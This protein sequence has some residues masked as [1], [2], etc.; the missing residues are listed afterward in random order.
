MPVALVD[1]LFAVGAV[2]DVPSWSLAGYAP[3]RIV[4]PRSTTSRCS[5]MR[6]M[7]G[8]GECGSNSLELAP[9]KP[10]TS[11]ANSMT[12]QWRPRHKPRNGR[13]C[14]RAKRAAA[15]LPSMPRKPNPPGITMPSRSLSRPSASRPSA[16]SDAIQSI[17]HPSRARVATVPKG[18]GDREIRVGKVHVLADQADAHL[19]VGGADSV[20]EVA[21][22]AELRRLALE[23][24]HLADVV[25]EALVV[26]HQRDL[27]EALGVDGGDDAGFGDVAELR[28]LLLE[29]G[30]DRPVRAAHDGVGLDAAAA[31]LGDRVLGRLRLLLT[32]RADERHQ[33]HV[34]VEDVLAADVLAELAD[35]PRGTGGSRCRRRCRRSR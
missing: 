20:H 32:R 17:E 16:S 14:S 2:D 3:S 23:M 27:V 13:R 33:R 24:Q 9:D 18:L 15:I 25:V 7:T 26:E 10:Q 11:R 4:P 8:W 34:D 21:P 29:P 5:S 30:R 12:A 19:L 28:D 35:R 1:D 22:L 31:Q 6:S